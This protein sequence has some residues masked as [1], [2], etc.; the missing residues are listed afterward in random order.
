M[1]WNL[2]GHEWAEHLLKEHILHDEV[3][4]AYLFTGASGTGRRSL[5]LEFACAINCLQPPAPGEFC[6][7]CRSCSQIL[8][9]QQT[10]LSIVKSEGEGGIIKVDQVRSLEHSLSLS[11]YEAKYRVAL[12]LD[13]QQ[14]N[15]N[16]QNALLKTLEEAPRQVILIL[17]ADS[18]E[19]LLPTISSRCEILRLRP[20]AVENLTSELISRWKL[21]PERAELFAH[22]ANGRVGA[23][24]QYENSPELLEK[25]SSLL[26][27]L[28]RLLSVS[29]R[30]R[31]VY[32]ESLCR[33]REAVRAALQCWYT[34]ARDLM[35]LVNGS[36]DEIANLDRKPELTGL[37]QKTDPALALRMVEA[38][39]HAL[40]ALEANGHLRLLVDMFFLDLPRIEK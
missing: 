9:L 10:D 13:F 27:D 17:T 33:N 5:A 35:L 18:A 14:A 28:Y 16:A 25:R 7:K 21:T 20:T 32:A 38:I 12:L 31:F 23:A 36:A 4:H 22:L 37:A 15:A 39:D 6:G 30:D 26:D 1:S 40:A 8:K 34:Y 2:I 24:L 29:R 11:P 3:R 19:N